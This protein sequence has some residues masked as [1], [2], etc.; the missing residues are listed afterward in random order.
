MIS[1]P[2]VGDGLFSSSEYRDEKA[3]ANTADEA[4]SL[5]REGIRIIGL[6]NGENQHIMKDARKIFGE[7]CV[8]PT[9]RVAMAVDLSLTAAPSITL[10]NTNV[11]IILPDWTNR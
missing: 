4:A 5:R 2:L 1:E 7:D 6:I 11:T 10:V 8:V 9:I 3:V